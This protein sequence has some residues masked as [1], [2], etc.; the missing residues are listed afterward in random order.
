MVIYGHLMTMSSSPKKKAPRQKRRSRSEPRDHAVRIAELKSR[1][2][3]YLRLVRS[4][5][6]VTV[7]DR[8]HEVAQ[9]SPIQSSSQPIEVPPPE[10]PFQSS[11]LESL[12]LPP[13]LRPADT[14]D[15]VAFLRKDRDQR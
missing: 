9:I 1:L 6:T 10:I 5:L 4:G 14:F 7:L 15:V 8:D 11:D 12:V 13:S 2:S 3:H